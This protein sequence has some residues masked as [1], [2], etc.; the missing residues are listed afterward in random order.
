LDNKIENG[1]VHKPINIY[2]PLLIFLLSVVAGTVSGLLLKNYN[3]FTYD[4]DGFGKL[5][6]HFAD[7]FNLDNSARRAPV[8][9]V[10][11]G[12]VYHLFGN[13]NQ[14]AMIIFHSIFLGL[15]GITDYRIAKKLFDD[16][17]ATPFIALVASLN[18]LLIWYIPYYFLEIVFTY[19]VLVTIWFAYLAFT[20]FKT[21]Y[22]ILFGIF[23]GI[24][25][26]TKGIALLFPVYLFVS[27]ILIMKIYPSLISNSK[28]K[29]L[30]KTG[31]IS[32]L[33]MLIVIFPWTLRN[34]LV[35]GEWILISTN[36]GVEFFRGN[37]FAEEN[38]YRLNSSLGPIFTKAIHRENQLLTEKGIVN[39]SEVQLDS[40]FNPLMIDFITKHPDQFLLKIV[41][42]IPAFWTLSTN[43]H[44]A[45][46]RLAI[47]LFT[48][49]FFILG[50]KRKPMRFNL[51]VFLTIL[52]FNLIY[53][54]I[55]AC[56]RYSLPLYPLMMISGA[57]F[58]FEII[59][60]FIFRKKEQW[61]SPQ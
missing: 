16:N 2:W 13:Y 44:T 45:R 57:Y 8:Y 6:A 21:K 55:Y 30:V 41:K 26:L 10:L 48:A 32:V 59:K 17:S 36:A 52:Y 47:F 37:V 49:S 61:L 38:S 33:F 18:P 1:S 7:H 4:V 50:W 25:A 15:I 31:L 14:V 24:T 39:P 12:L 27:L 29:N 51:F 58:A 35:K 53:A 5:A 54:A 11:L 28:T 60:K 20:K 22:A 56:A 3:M 34:K 9:P 46:I 19:L 43:Q 40:I 42:Q 23:S